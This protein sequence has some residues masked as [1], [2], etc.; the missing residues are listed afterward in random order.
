MVKRAR[1]L[2]DRVD[3]AFVVAN[4]ASVMGSEETRTLLVDG[5]DALE[6]DGTKADLGARVADRLADDLA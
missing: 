3:L 5:E 6:V 4:D 1:S 2:R